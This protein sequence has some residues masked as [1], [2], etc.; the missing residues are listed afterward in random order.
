MHYG[1]W[2]IRPPPAGALSWEVGNS[3]STGITY[4]E[5]RENKIKTR[6]ARDTVKPAE[7]GVVAG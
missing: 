1:W 4:A 7:A 5:V 6:S 2:P 3:P